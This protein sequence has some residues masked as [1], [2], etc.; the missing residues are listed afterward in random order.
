MR[1]LGR[2]GMALHK[3]RGELAM[4]RDDLPKASSP[5]NRESVFHS[6]GVSHSHS[7]NES[8]SQS[9]P[10]SVQRFSNTVLEFNGWTDATPYF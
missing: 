3:V 8:Q 7:R 1:G 10:R 5:K 6:T 4:A 2:A 9:Q